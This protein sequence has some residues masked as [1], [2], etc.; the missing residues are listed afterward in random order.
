M[1]SGSKIKEYTKILSKKKLKI[2][3]RLERKQWEEQ[4]L[5]IVTVKNIHCEIANIC[6]YFYTYFVFP[7]IN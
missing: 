4:Y 5:P 7:P 2:A 6:E 1:E 3:G